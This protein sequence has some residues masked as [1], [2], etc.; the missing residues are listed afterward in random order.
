MIS[1]LP[2]VDRG[3]SHPG[4]S[5]KRTTIATVGIPSKIAPIFPNRIL[6]PYKERRNSFNNSTNNP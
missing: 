3:V 1:N 2:K 5:A 6:S 4:R